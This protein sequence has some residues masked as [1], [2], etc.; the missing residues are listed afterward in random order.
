MYKRQ[1]S[2]G[3]TS[4]TGDREQGGLYVDADTSATGGD[5]SNEHR[6]YGVWSDTRVNSSAD[7][8]AVYAVYG[9]SE[10]QRSGTSGMT[11]ITNLAGG[12]FIGAGDAN[13][14]APTISTLYG[15]YGSANN[16][17]LGR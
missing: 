10:D 7:P 15:V 12:W 9:Y 5:Q 8:D 16:K 13:N 2:S 3:S 11:A 4:V 14:S 1:D 6:L 17:T